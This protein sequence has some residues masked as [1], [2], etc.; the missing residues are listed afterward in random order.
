MAKLFLDGIFGFDSKSPSTVRIKLLNP[1]K[2]V[3]Y[4]VD[5]RGLMAGEISFSAQNKWGPVINDLANL[6]DLASL[7][8]SESMFSWISAS[9]MCWKGTSPL[10]IGIE[11]YLI[12]YKRG[13][14]LEGQLRN[15]VKLGSLS[16]DSNAGI[17]KDFKVLVHGGYAADI[18]SGNNKYFANK[19]FKEIKDI[20]DSRNKFGFQDY[21][22]DLYSGDL[23]SG[24]AVAQ[25]S[26]S[27]R[28][29]GKSEIRN[30]LLSKVS[31]TES[32]IEVANQNGEERK[33]LYYRVSAQFTGVRP[34]LSV[35][36]DRMFNFAV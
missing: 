16:K 9:T 31:V 11:F 14:D 2:Q 27:I 28:F 4:L 20:Q 5:L 29:G 33:P 17:G 19:G 13:L 3:D 25:G 21:D 15:F 10:S 18:L 7:L 32:V 30:L 22:K 1:S 24:D 34:L 36:V 23:Y 26:L 12:N 8:G 35:D 6:Q